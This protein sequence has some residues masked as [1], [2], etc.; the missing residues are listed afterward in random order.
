MKPRLLYEFQV[1]RRRRPAT[2][3]K[4][5]HTGG[6]R[7]KFREETPVTRQEEE[8]P[9]PVGDYSSPLAPASTQILPLMQ[10]EYAFAARFACLSCRLP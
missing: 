7:A 1:T 9:R 3:K 8:A 4:A 2:K 6:G 10:Q 5:L